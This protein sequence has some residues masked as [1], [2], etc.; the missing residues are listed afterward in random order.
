VSKVKGEEGGSVPKVKGEVGRVMVN[1]LKEL[2]A[3][4]KELDE[5]ISQLKKERANLRGQIV[6]FQTPGIGSGMASPRP[7]VK[8]ERESMGRQMTPEVI[9]LT[10]L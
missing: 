10:D 3:K 6:D 4:E 2:E 1:G 7:G 8:T 5:Q 9:D